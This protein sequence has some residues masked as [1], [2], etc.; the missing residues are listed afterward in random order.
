MS[1]AMQLDLFAPVRAPA[2]VLT[3]EPDGFVV[4]GDVDETLT[5]PHPRYAWDRARIEL[6]RHDNGLWMWSASYNYGN[7][8]SGYRVGPK[9]GKFAETREDALHYAVAEMKQHLEPVPEA[10]AS[11][12][13]RWLD[14]LT[15]TPL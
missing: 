5:L 10:D 9:W 12:I 2:V 4:S 1:G 14:T 8:G 3:V 11:L 7:G 13:R 6:H 15:P